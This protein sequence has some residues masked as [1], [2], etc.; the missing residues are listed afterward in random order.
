MKRDP[1]AVVSH[2]TRETT[3]SLVMQQFR[4]PRP[5]LH[6]GCFVLKNAAEAKPLP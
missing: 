3:A 2:M 6:H 1:F 5:R 4:E